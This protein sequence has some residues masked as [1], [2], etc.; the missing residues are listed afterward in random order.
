MA[1]KFTAASRLSHA[2][3]SVRRGLL[4]SSGDGF[5]QTGFVKASL[6]VLDRCF[7]R[8]QECHASTTLK[9]GT[10]SRVLTGG[11]DNCVKHKTTPHTEIIREGSCEISNALRSAVL[12]HQAT[13][14]KKVRVK[15]VAAPDRLNF[16]DIEAQTRVSIQGSSK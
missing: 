10:P 16:K 13:A 8:R 6:E 2:S 15:I 14:E 12:I 3:K 1:A 4:S 5:L 7:T 11:G 9:P